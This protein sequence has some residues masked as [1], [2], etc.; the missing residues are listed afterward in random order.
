MLDI[1]YEGLNGR[2]WL[3]ATVDQHVT[4]TATPSRRS[5]Q[6]AMGFRVAHPGSVL[7]GNQVEALAAE[8]GGLHADAVFKVHR[9]DV[10]GIHVELH[11]VGQLAHLYWRHFRDWKG[12]VE[13]TRLD[14][15]GLKDYGALCGWTL[16][17]AHARSGNRRAIS[18]WMGE[19]K[20]FASMLL[21]R[22]LTHAH[23]VELDHRAFVEAID[24]GRLSAG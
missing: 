9:V 17:K 10:M 8:P 3:E 2:H 1:A 13:L 21:E 23:H 11:K 5:G 18:A 14:A 19:P 4:S 20:A 24:Q 12:S 6:M 15:R 16:A 22:A 7:K